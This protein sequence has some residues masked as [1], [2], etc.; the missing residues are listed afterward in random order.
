MISHKDEQLEAVSQ[1]M[2]TVP[3]AAEFLGVCNDTIHELMDG[4]QIE[5]VDYTKPSNRRRIR[6]PTRKSVME[7]AAK[8][9]V[10]TGHRD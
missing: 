7:Y 2:M 1:G 8:R 10:L 5:Y 9:V 3:D 6:R 4:G